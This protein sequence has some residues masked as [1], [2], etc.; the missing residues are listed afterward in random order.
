MRLAIV[1]S[2]WT[3]K[4]TLIN[5]LE[6]EWYNKIIDLEREIIW[7]TNIGNLNQEDINLKVYNSIIWS[8]NTY[9]NF[10]T[11]TS[12]IDNL[13][14]TYK[15]S[16]NL[17]PIINKDI[18][19]DIIF[20][21]PIEFELEY[22]WIRH[23]DKQLQIEIDMIIKQLIQS[24]SRVYVINWSLDERVLKINNILWINTITN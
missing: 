13:A 20:Y 21:L 10:I 2:F 11:N 8:E 16:P 7:D 3:W 24:H 12:R 22:D 18:N 14:Y 1:G 4:T 23:N 9:K 17:F 5:A 6:L 19:Y 15:F